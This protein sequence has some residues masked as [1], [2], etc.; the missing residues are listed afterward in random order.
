MVS[1]LIVSQSAKIAAAVVDLA[2]EIGA[3]P[4]EFTAC[5]VGR[6]EILAALESVYR[7]TGV[8]VLV[9]GKRAKNSVLEAIELLETEKQN[10]VKLCNAPLVEG[11]IAIA[12]EISTNADLD[13]VLTIVESIAKAEKEEFRQEKLIINQKVS[14]NLIADLVNL[15][16]EF[17]AKITLE[18]LH[19]NL[20]P[21]DVKS[22]DLVLSLGIKRGDEIVIAAVGE[23]K[24]EA[25]DALSQLLGRKELIIGSPERE[26][27]ISFTAIP[28]V[29]G[30]A[31][32]TT[33]FYRPLLPEISQEKNENSVREWEK[34]KEAI[35][36]LKKEINYFITENNRHI[37]GICLLFLEDINWIGRIRKLIFEREYTAANAWKTIVEESL[38]NYEKDLE[39]YLENLLTNIGIRILQLLAEELNSVELDRSGIIFAYDLSP[40]EMINLN[41]ETVLGICLAA[42]SIKSETVKIAATKGIPMV[43]GLGAKLWNIPANTEIVIDG[44]TGQINTQANEDQ[45]AEL[46]LKQDLQRNQNEWGLEPTTQDGYNIPLTANL[47]GVEDAERAVKLGIEGIGLFDSKYLFLDRLKDPEEA[48]QLAVYRAIAAVLEDR[49]LTILTLDMLNFQETN[50]LLGWHGIRQTLDSPNLFKTQLKAILKASIEANIRILLPMVTSIQEINAAKA[51]ISEVKQELATAKID[52]AETIPL[53]IMVQSPAAIITIDRLAPEVDFL[54]ISTDDLAQYIMAADRTNFKVAHLADPFEPAVLR[55]IQQVVIAAKVRGIGVAACGQMACD[56]LGIPI[57]LGLGVDELIVNN[58][59]FLEV[60]KYIARFNLEEAEDLVKNLLQ[61]ESGIA[62]RQS[63][64]NVLSGI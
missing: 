58:N 10:R 30:V 29:G 64:F 48:E 8:A 15:A 61:L 49:P 9:D 14:L 19:H 43:I 40:A 24:I 38:A 18:N 60:M 45:L 25:I 27:E 42:G 3:G 34:L 51:I 57:L 4:I 21:V 52:C 7:E 35:D 54:T 26:K 1:I 12:S 53:G 6:V 13:R 55:S 39:P 33:I 17:R 59:S 20:A 37:F 22:I 41:N 2:K 62:V 46:N 47:V 16:R 44:Y 11:A 23:N 32:G 5:G 56:S 28:A 31:A 63:V 36:Y 50:S